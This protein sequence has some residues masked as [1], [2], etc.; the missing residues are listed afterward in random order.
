MRRRVSMFVQEARVSSFLPIYS[1]SLLLFDCN[2]FCLKRRPAHI[3]CHIRPQQHTAEQVCLDPSFFL[4][5]S[6]PQLPYVVVVGSAGCYKFHRHH[7]L[8][9]SFFSFVPVKSLHLLSN[10]NSC[11]L[12]LGRLGQSPCFHLYKSIEEPTSMQV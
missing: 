3:S 1:L 12:A 6:T 8:S 9:F 10:L 5:W 11:N 7:F 2:P 4:W